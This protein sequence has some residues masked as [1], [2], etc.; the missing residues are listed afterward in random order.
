MRLIA[1][2]SKRRYDLDLAY[3]DQAKAQRLDLYRPVDTDG[4]PLP[5]VAVIHGGAF[6]VGDKAD[7]R[8]LATTLVARGYAVASVNY[9]MAPASTFPAAV[10]DVRAAVRW[11]RVNAKSYELD[12][13]RVA[14]LGE[15]AGGYLAATLGTGGDQD[16]P[17]DAELGNA[18]VPST[19]RAV[20]DLYG[21]MNFGAMDEQ[22]RAN[23]R[24]G[25]EAIYHDGAR[26][27]ESL[28]LGQQL[29]LAPG[30]VRA[31]DPA[32]GLSAGRTPPPFLI[33]HGTADCTVPYQQSA[34]LADALRAAGGTVTLN[35]LDGAG[36][37]SDFPVTSRI[38]GIAA[39]L[40][41]ALR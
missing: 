19:V 22:L 40:E 37:G 30:L 18:D 10:L 1:R 8:P 6:Q 32:S 36:H 41:E 28:F 2:R 31:A 13:G 27:P 12:G 17:G 23:P 7:L 35:L 21:P 20:V 25:P 38:P 15:S 16:L 24:C 4:A 3:A 26:S 34:G 39:F 11:L 5:V 29:T 33:E 9:R 14:V